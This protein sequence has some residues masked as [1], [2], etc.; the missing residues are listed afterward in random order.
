MFLKL[1]FNLI[2]QVEDSDESVFGSS[3]ARQN[4][5]WKHHTPTQITCIVGEFNKAIALLVIGVK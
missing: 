1:E 4:A 2:I 5:L 3:T